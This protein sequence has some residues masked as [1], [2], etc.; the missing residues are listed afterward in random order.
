MANLT[1][2]VIRKLYGERDIDV[3]FENNIKVIVAENGYGKTTLLNALYATLSGDISKL[4]QIPFTSIEIAFDDN[5][6][7]LLKKDDFSLATSVFRKS[8]FYQHLRSTIGSDR[9]YDLLE[10]YISLPI[11]QFRR[12]RIF[13][14]TRA[15][16]EIPAAALIN[17]LRELLEDEEKEQKLNILNVRK[18]LKEIGSKNDYNFLYLP[19]YRRVE[20]DF[21]DINTDDENDLVIDD[22]INFGMRDVDKKIKEI[23]TEIVNS[24]VEWFSKVNGEML[25]QLIEGFNLDDS[26]KAAV[27]NPESIKIVLDRI[28]DNIE[29]EYKQRILDLIDSGEIFSNHTPLIYFLANLLKVYEQQKDN[30]KCLQEFTDV[31]NRYLGDKK[32]EYNES[33]VSVD[34]V[35][36]KNGRSVDIETLSSGEKQIISLFAK[37]YLQKEDNIAIFL[38]EPEL[39]L[40]IEWQK[41]ILPDIVNSGRCVFLFT[42]THSPFIFE[43]E[44]IDNTVDLSRYIK[45]L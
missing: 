41:T 44:L 8:G 13:N 5:S 22:S 32:L 20:Q 10:A 39:S 40:S 12:S 42:T 33:N 31:C 11:N 29:K 43:N 45:E 34:I 3:T 25:S 15:K 28:G 16:F 21:R 14:L 30:D 9:L 7:F 37:L 4:R 24:S 6:K 18:T 17:L 1:R 23:T 2:F 27:K 26:Q 19:T 36:R 38:D 35:R